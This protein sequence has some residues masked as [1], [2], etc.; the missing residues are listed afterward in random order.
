[1]TGI[2]SKPMTLL[3]PVGQT[4]VCKKGA[5]VPG[6]RTHWGQPHPVHWTMATYSSQAKVTLLLESRGR[7]L[8]PFQ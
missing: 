4:D 2:E 8:F 5:A 1:M 7:L 6:A 3:S